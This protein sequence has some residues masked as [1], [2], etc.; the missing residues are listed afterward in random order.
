[1]SKVRVAL[2]GKTHSVFLGILKS[3]GSLE[4]L[5]LLIIFKVPVY[6]KD[7]ECFGF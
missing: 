4:V 7:F 2:W 1:M 5:T 3:G 6:E